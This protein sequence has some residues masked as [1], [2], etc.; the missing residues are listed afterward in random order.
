[1]ND[2]TIDSEMRRRLSV[3]RDGNLTSDQWLKLSL[4]PMTP[5]LFV[6]IPAVLLLTVRFRVAGFLVA[7]LGGLGLLLVFI[8]QRLS[9]YARLPLSYEVMTAS[10]D[11][12]GTSKGQFDFV[13]E[14]DEV[15]RFSRHITDGITSQRGSP[16]HVYYLVDGRSRVLLSMAPYAKEDTRAWEPT[17]VFKSRY[18]KRVQDKPKGKPKRR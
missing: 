16:Y 2:L 1:M 17:A 14:R 9:H 8:T 11:H 12:R 4:V 18:E 15:V 6:F 13:D 3:N 5:A 7:L 10:D